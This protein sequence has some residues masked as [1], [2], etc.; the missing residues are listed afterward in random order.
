M[1]SPADDSNSNE[2]PNPDLVPRNT[3]QDMVVIRENHTIGMDLPGENTKWVQDTSL[4]REK[5][6][7]QRN[8][9]PMETKT[10]FPISDRTH[11][12]TQKWRDST[13]PSLNYSNNAQST[14]GQK[15]LSDIT[16][17]LSQVHIEAPQSHSATQT[18][19][20]YG[21]RRPVGEPLKLAECSSYHGQSFVKCGKG[22]M[23]VGSATSS[24]SREEKSKYPNTDK[25]FEVGI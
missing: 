14:L 9:T 18:Y 24:S 16:F 13:D 23:R 10:S 17:D 7:R 21:G 5:K 1:T 20:G 6:P 4:T 3:S 25:Y 19:S 12:K 8:A 2:M 11:D 15:R 22:G